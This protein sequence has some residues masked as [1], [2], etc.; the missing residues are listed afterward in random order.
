MSGERETCDELT[1]A[2]CI[3][4]AVLNVRETEIPGVLIVEPS[5]LTDARGWFME[6]FNA[7]TFAAH[8]LPVEFAQDNQSLSKR[9]VVRGL[10]YQLERPQGKLVRCIRGSIL[11]VAV[12]IRR[13]SP[14]FGRSVAV[15]LSAE[16]R[17]MLWIPPRF[18][19]G[20]RTLSKE[21]EVLYKCTTLWHAA[22][23][24]ILLWNDPDL[25]IDWGIEAPT[26]SE[27][28]A[29]GRPLRNAEIFES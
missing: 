1:S 12:D 28:D 6:F 29:V 26:L 17:L 16:N 2:S 27:K 25:A 13:S 20:F 18:A 19:H 11:D 4:R 15:E 23:D 8:G 14:T 9:D 21:A 24:R 10:H 3:I 7:S 22:S 5:L